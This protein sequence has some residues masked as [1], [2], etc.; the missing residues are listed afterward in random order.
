MGLTIRFQIRKHRCTPGVRVLKASPNAQAFRTSHLPC[1]CQD[2]K[3]TPSFQ[4]ILPGVPGQGPWKSRCL[5]GH[6]SAHPGPCQGLDF[7]C[8]SCCNLTINECGGS[9]LEPELEETDLFQIHKLCCYQLS[10]DHTIEA[11]LVTEA[12][13]LPCEFLSP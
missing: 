11:N 8:A 12:L 2:T 3:R 5:P 1:G 6:L 10:T 9:G 7:N 4:V 13:G